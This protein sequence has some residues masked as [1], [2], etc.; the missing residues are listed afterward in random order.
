MTQVKSHTRKTKTGR[1]AVKAHSRKRPTIRDLNEKISEL[2]E[3]ILIRRGNEPLDGDETGE[4]A[5]LV[6][7]RLDSSHGND[8]ENE[9]T[10][11]LNKLDW[12]VFE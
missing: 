5:K 3:M 12:G 6:R 4:V 2:S 9:T 8:T 11:K 7:I 10:R 1:V